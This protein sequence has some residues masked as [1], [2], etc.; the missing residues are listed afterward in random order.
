MSVFTRVFHNGVIRTMVVIEFFGTAAYGIIGPV[1]A[2]F[3]ADVIEGGSVKVAGF[4]IA[5]LWVTKAIIQLPIARFID[6]TKGERDDFWIYFGGQVLFALGIFFFVFAQTPTHIYL[7]QIIIGVAVAMVTP[8]L[9][10]VFS[11]HLDKHYESF[12][13]SMYSVFS[14]S[15]GTAIAGAASGLI[16]IA[17][18]FQ[19]LF[20]ISAS[21]FAVMAFLT[22]VLLKSKI[23]PQSIRPRR[24]IDVIPE[25][26]R[27]P[28]AK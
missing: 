8:A 20:I 22:F 4:A 14:Y 16:V 12:E 9:Y 7:I 24:P 2:I 21:L 5:I 11:R 13:W 17:F 25:H 1:F 6:R 23:D 18:G 28:G 19:T 27:H 26:H 10:G 15:V 3:A